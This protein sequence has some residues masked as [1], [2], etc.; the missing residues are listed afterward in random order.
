MRINAAHQKL[1]KNKLYGFNVNTEQWDNIE[2]KAL[3][4]SSQRWVSSRLSFMTRRVLLTDKPLLPYK[5]IKIDDSNH[6]NILYSE[7]PNQRGRGTF[8]YDYTTIDATHEARTVTFNTTKSLSG[9]EASVVEVLSGPFPI[10]MGRYAGTN[11]QV[12]DN[13]LYSRIAA[14]I[15]DDVLI[16]TDNELVVG[17]DRYIVEEA[18]PELHTTVLMLTKR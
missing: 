18:F 14:Y 10:H 2:C 15:P 13:H 8:L 1:A 11:S 3:L 6:I 5:S 4:E 16:S 9:M 7:Q 17:G 12:T